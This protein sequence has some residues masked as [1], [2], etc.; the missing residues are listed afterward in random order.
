MQTSQAQQA[1]LVKFKEPQHFMKMKD[2]DMVM[3][4]QKNG[5]AFSVHNTVLRICPL[6]DFHPH[7]TSW[8]RNICIY[9]HH[10]YIC[11]THQKL[12]SKH[13]SF[14]IRTLSDDQHC[15]ITPGAG[16]VPG[17]SL[18][19]RVAAWLFPIYY[20]HTYIYICVYIYIYDVCYCLLLHG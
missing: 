17:G 4:S 5:S 19:N 15:E 3:N 11:W 13:I 14:F 6:S 1:L 7:P 16:S 18:A 10:I 2:P 8:M 20:L 12:E 9:I